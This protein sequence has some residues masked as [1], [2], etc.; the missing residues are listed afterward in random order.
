MHTY[1]DEAGKYRYE[2]YLIKIFHFL[3]V[4]R[5]FLFYFENNLT[6]NAATLTTVFFLVYCFHSNIVY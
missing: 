5:N 6:G 4:K 3:V 1:L 2:E